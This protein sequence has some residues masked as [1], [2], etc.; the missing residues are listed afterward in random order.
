MSATAPPASWRAQTNSPASS[1]PGRGAPSPPIT[2]ALSAQVGLRWSRVAQR[3]EGRRGL[4]AEDLEFQHPAGMRSLA[5]NAQKQREASASGSQDWVTSSSLASRSTCH[6]S[7]VPAPGHAG[8]RAPSPGP[9]DSSGTP[10]PVNCVRP[11]GWCTESTAF[12]SSLDCDGDGY[13]SAFAHWQR[14]QGACAC[15]LVQA[16]AL[17][18][19]GFTVQQ[20]AAHPP[21]A[22]LSSC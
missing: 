4:W 5:A 21:G 11:P 6:H 14:L 17:T 3:R 18:A 7:I 22:G 1:T 8:V 20:D 13:V 10:K 15:F 19:D 16:S 9:L 12:Y 2:T